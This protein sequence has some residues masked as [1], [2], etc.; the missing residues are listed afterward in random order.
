MARTRIFR[1]TTL[2]IYVGTGKVSGDSVIIAP[3]GGKIKGVCLTDADASGMATIEL[4][5]ERVVHRLSVVGSNAVETS[6]LS[7]A[8]AVAMGDIIYK[9]TSTGLLAV[10]ASGGVQYGI[11]LGTP[12]DDGAYASGTVVSAGATASCDIM[13]GV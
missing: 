9:H 11:A 13:L 3:S 10:D 2:R 6:P 8:T 7:G 1:T 12:D 5:G 4:D